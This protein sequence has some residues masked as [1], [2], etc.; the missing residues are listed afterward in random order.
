VA[1]RVHDIDFGVVEKE[2]GV[3]GEDGDAAFALEIVGIHDALDEFLIGA[4]DAGLAEHGVYE[5][6]FAVVD[7]SDDSDIADLLTHK[8]FICL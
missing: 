6:G 3:F 1:G 2:R 8:S 7:V 4:E 5:S